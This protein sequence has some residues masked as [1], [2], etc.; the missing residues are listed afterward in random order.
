MYRIPT[1][2][3][4]R[5]SCRKQHWP[6]K[7][8]RARKRLVLT[9]NALHLRVAMIT[10]LPKADVRDGFIPLKCE[11]LVRRTTTLQHGGLSG[12]E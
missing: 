12:S 10:P 1:S 3:L 6:T 11:L 8:G 9:R 2:R 4:S 5:L 7:L